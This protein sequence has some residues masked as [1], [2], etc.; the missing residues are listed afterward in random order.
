MHCLDVELS[1]LLG[2]LAVT[3]EGSGSAAAGL[4]HRHVNNVADGVEVRNDSLGDVYISEVKQTS[5]EHSDLALG[6]VDLLLDGREDIAERHGSNAHQ[7]SALCHAG[8]EH[9]QMTDEIGALGEGSLCHGGDT[10]HGVEQLSVADCIQSEFINGIGICLVA[11]LTQFHDHLGDVKSAAA[12]L[13]AASALQADVLDLVRSLLRDQ[14]VGQNGADT[15]G[16]DLGAIYMAAQQSECRT[17]VKTCATADAVVDFPE[18]RIRQ[19]GAASR[20]VQNDCVEFFL[21]L[22]I[23][24]LVHGHLR[25]ACVHGN[26]RSDTLARA[27][28]GKGLKDVT[29]IGEALDELLDTEDIQMDLGQC[30]DHTAVALVTH[31]ENGARLGDS[32]VCA[33]NT[34]VCMDELVA[35]DLPGGLDLLG[36]DGLVLLFC[37]LSE[38]IS[39]LLFV[40][41]QGRHDHVYGSVAFEG[42]DELAEVGL[43][44][45]YTVVAQNMVHVDFL[46]SH[47]F[48]L[49]DGLDA[50]FLYEAPDILHC[51]FAAL[52]MEDM[53]AACRAVLCEIIDH[54]IDVVGCVALDF[55]DA[56]TCRLKVDAGI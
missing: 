8:Q 26:I 7:A 47:G 6:I 33:G 27:I 38:I 5:G 36:D 43:L 51:L 17:Y 54:L 11:A 50:F 9:R 31:G 32:H 44:N 10:Q 4:T 29:G 20:I 45:L 23:G 13:F 55:L 14:E 3:H 16:V 40:Q 46:R 15:A 19:D 48:G 28:A 56:V 53:S 18:I 1:G 52:C 24:I 35:H 34:H 41:M 30:T 49:D 12:D 39:D 21:S 42:D 25:S 22:L 2:V 37:I